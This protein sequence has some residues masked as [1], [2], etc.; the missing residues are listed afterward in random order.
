MATPTLRRCDRRFHRH[1]SATCSGVTSS[2]SMAACRG[3]INSSPTAP[4]RGHPKRG[5]A[6]SG[7]PGVC[8]PGILTWRY[9]FP[10]HSRRRL[11]CK[12]AMIPRVVGYDRDGRG[13]LLTDKL[14]PVKEKGKFVPVPLVKT[15][16]GLA[17]YI[18]APKGT[19]GWSCSSPKTK[20][21]TPARCCSAAVY[22]QRSP[23][24]GGL[25]RFAAGPAESRRTVRA[26][27]SA[28]GQSTSQS[29]PTA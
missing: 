3:R 1:I 4:A 21:A 22:R 25:G 27:P 11:L 17:H 12:M 18:G 28:G 23:P 20:H 15:Y 9:C 5:K 8:G 19:C 13:F 2:R 26:L 14:L 24:P 6:S 7:L 16:L 10:I 29:S